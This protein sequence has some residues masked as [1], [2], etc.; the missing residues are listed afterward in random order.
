MERPD[1]R[2]PSLDDDNSVVAG[3]DDVDISG[4]LSLVVDD[5]RT[6]FATPPDDDV[7]SRHLQSM[8]AAQAAMGKVATT[9]NRR[10]RR[11]LVGLGLAVGVV[12]LSGSLATAGA[13]PRPVQDAVATMVAPLG[14]ELPHSDT[15][16]AI[17]AGAPDTE[18]PANPSG[19]GVENRPSDLPGAGE[20]APGITGEGPG[21]GVRTPVDPPRPAPGPPQG[22]PQPPV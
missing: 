6:A 19:A 13:L 15:T 12:G 20:S 8:L 10:R 17:D 9:P 14:F 4:E 18:P 3:S 7:S 16:D 22:V 1:P 11:R 21:Q 5:L 2:H